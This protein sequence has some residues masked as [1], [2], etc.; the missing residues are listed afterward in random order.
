MTK[1]ND[2]P[3]LLDPRLVRAL[4]HP[5]RTHL[6]MTLSDRI[7]TP[8][9]LANE[10]RCPIRHVAYHLGILE[11]L[12]CVELVRTEESP[13]GKVIA[14]YY[15]AT[16]R[17]WFDRE[18]WQVVGDAGRPNITMGILGTM[19]EDLTKAVLADTIDE[20]ENHISRTPA[21]LDEVGYEELLVLLNDT[22]ERVIDIQTESANRLK[23]GGKEI[24][25]K[26]HLVQFISPDPK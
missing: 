11:D 8:K 16:E 10:L 4:G 26:I 20:G 14:H 1:K 25:T 5:T 6:L 15:R 7:E 24:M 2:T 13:G 21:I 12:G 3:P 23:D 17:L 9:N 19:S 18:A 22:L